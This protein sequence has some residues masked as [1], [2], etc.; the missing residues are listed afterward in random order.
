MELMIY[1][2][3]YGTSAMAKGHV[4]LPEFMAAVR[5]EVD[6]D[7]PILG[8]EPEHTWMRYTYDFQERRRCI[9]EARPGSRG[10]FKATF[11][12]CA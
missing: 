4:P 9:E 7:D 6:E 11:I 12:Q 3:D 1:R 10:A 2:D 5:A 8:E